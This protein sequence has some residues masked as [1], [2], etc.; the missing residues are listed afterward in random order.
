MSDYAYM[1]G[2]YYCSLSEIG[3]VFAISECGE[4]IHCATLDVNLRGFGRICAVDGVWRDWLHPWSIESNK[5]VI[6][7]PTIKTDKHSTVW[8]WAMRFCIEYEWGGNN[9]SERAK[10]DAL[11]ADDF[12]DVL[13]SLYIDDWSDID[14]YNSILLFDDMA[15]NILAR[16]ALW[17]SRNYKKESNNSLF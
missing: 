15:K 10:M 3:K 9:E 5:P 13:Q 4:M 1:K 2:G 12:K 11:A 14:D 17:F 16:E 8:E 6:L 7:P